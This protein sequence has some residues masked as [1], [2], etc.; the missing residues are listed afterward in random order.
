MDNEKKYLRILF[1]GGATGGHLYPAI[2]LCEQFQ[3]QLG[4]D[5]VKL[6]FIGTRKGLENR[7]LPR[8][9]YPLKTI[10]IK[11]IQRGFSLRDILIN[12]LAPFRIVV[13]LIHSY[14]IIK[15][16]DP[17]LAIGT[18]GYAAGPAL[19]IAGR[20]EIPV[21]LHEQNVFPG[22]TTR[23]LK[24]YAR[25]IYV[26][27][28]D[29]GKYLENAVPLGT[30][31]RRSLRSIAQGQARQYFELQ[32]EKPTI[33]IFGGSQGSLA[34]NQ[35]MQANMDLFLAEL[36]CQ[37]IWQTGVSEYDS[38]A[39]SFIDDPR[40]QIT[41]F[42]HEMGL[43]Y[44]AADLVI[45]RA[46][47]LTLSELCLFG[48]PSVLI[49]LPTAAENHQ[50]INARVME[51]EGASQVVLQSSLAVDSFLNILERLI[52]NP[53][54]LSEMA[55]RARALSHPQAARA[56]VTDILKSIDSQNDV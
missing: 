36:D 47:A 49:P 54:K 18:G 20:M 41:D 35:F 31:L 29:T 19:Y 4:S 25:R 2:A 24:K 50:E 42:I 6:L 8:L 12:I 10:W 46:G 16:F 22:A 37:C 15:N 5:N 7:V 39:E 55:S 3:A 52:G 27:Y 48:K 32:P 56:I 33:L 23:L 17:D 30:P 14:F 1:S 13:S 34:I 38:I 9:G 40:L 28:A 43:A 44:S 53:R 51:K 11:G 21:F 26:S 45:C